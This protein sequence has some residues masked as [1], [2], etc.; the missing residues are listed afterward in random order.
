MILIESCGRKLGT[1]HSSIEDTANPVRFAKPW[2]DRLKNLESRSSASTLWRAPHGKDTV[3]CITHRNFSLQNIVVLNDA[4]GEP[5]L[6]EVHLLYPALGV[7]GALLPLID[8]APGLRDLASGYR[9]IELN[10]FSID[11][12]MSVELRRCLF[13]GWCENAPSLWSLSL[14]HI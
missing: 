12:G 10:D 6:R 4:S 3:G 14:I 8:R 2:N 11:S 13:D 7:Y 1:F 9:S 5:N